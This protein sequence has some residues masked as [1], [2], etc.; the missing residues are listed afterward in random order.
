MNWEI[1][2]SLITLLLLIPL[3]SAWA[4]PYHA[5]GS[6]YAGSGEIW[7]ADAGN[8]LFD[9][10]LHGDELAGD[11]IHGG[12]IKSD[13]PPG[14]HEW[15]I[16][17][18]DWS[19]A[20]PSNPDYPLANAVMVYGSAS[21]YIHFRLDT[22]HRGEGWQPSSN[23]VACSHF[24]WPNEA[25]FELIGSAPEL[26]DWLAGIPLVMDESRW[27]AFATIG[28]PGAHEF[29][30]RVQG[31]W[32]YCNL[33]VHYNMYR[34]DNYRFETSAPQTLVRFEF[35]PK[36]GRGRAYVEGSVAAEPSRWGD[37]KALYR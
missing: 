34:G 2:I 36:D 24:A 21:E 13:Q 29:K 33:G 19:A 14:F 7:H 9:D 26:G 10:G 18:A 22:N 23:A 25:Q 4:G 28:T 8:E 35:D 15:K 1:R 3:G 11:G 30:F 27:T 37:V 12:W 31:T 5:R 16:A 17:T 20:Y 32:D 6:F